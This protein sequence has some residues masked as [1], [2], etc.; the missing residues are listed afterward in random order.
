MSGCQASDCAQDE[1][2]D[3]AGGEVA[4][5]GLRRIASNRAVDAEM[6]D[7][8]YLLRLVPEGI[9]L[10]IWVNAQ[11]LLSTPTPARRDLAIVAA[12][13]WSRFRKEGN[14][15]E[16]DEPVVTLHVGVRVVEDRCQT[17]AG[18]VGET[19]HPEIDVVP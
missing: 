9:H 4:H 2:G 16:G 15:R 19:E 6:R 7:A 1:V 12:F 13:R 17:V 3:E 5:V 11:I 14:P 8:E 18:A 10:S